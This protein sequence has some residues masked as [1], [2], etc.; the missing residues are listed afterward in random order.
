MVVTWVTFSSVNTSFVEYGIFDLNMV[1]KGIEDKFQDGGDE[2]RILYMHRVKMIGLKEKCIYR[3][4]S[5]K[6][7]WYN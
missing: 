5:T 6:Q 7:S 1:A 2:K 3:K 4:Y